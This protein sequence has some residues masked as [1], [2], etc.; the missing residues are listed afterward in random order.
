MR[1]GNIPESENMVQ[2]NLVA[3]CWEII[4]LSNTYANG[5]FEITKDTT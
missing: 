2:W 4:K 1:E 3:E 5:A